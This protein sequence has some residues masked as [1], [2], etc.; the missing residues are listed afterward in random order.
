MPPSLTASTASTLPF[1][2]DNVDGLDDVG[3]LDTG[4]RVADLADA[5][6]IGV[7]PLDDVIGR[8]PVPAGTRPACTA[9]PRP[10]GSHR[11]RRSASHGRG[12]GR[13]TRSD[14]TRL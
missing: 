7:H 8:R 3:G 2:A 13:L 11:R 10:T 6:Y 5:K 9:R 14:M 4:E 1:G 12:S